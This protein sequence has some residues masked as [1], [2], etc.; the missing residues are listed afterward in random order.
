MVGAIQATPTLRDRT[1]DEMELLF[2]L[3][4]SDSTQNQGTAP[5][6][7]RTAGSPDLDVAGENG[8]RVK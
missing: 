7:H 4:K 2:L 8:D 3:T 1:I 6:I 5:L